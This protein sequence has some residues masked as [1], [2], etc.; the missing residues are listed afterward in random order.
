ML[1]IERRKCHSDAARASSGA[2]ALL[3]MHQEKRDG[4]GRQAREFVLPVPVSVA[5]PPADIGAPRSTT[6]SPPHSP[7]PP[8]RPDRHGACGGRSPRSGASDSPSTSPARPPAASPARRAEHRRANPPCR[9][10]RADAAT[11]PDPRTRSRDGEK[12]ER[13]RFARQRLTE[14]ARAA[15]RPHRPGVPAPPTRRASSPDTASRLRAKNSHRASS[16]SPISRPS[17]GET[18][19]RVVFAQRQAILGA[20]GEHAI[21]LRRAARDQIVDQHADIGLAA[22][23]APRL[24]LGAG[25]RRIDA[26]EQTLRRRL[27][28]ARGA[29]D[30]AGE[31]Q[32]ADELALQARLQTP[33][34]EEIVFD[35][36]AGAR[37]VRALEA[38]EWCARSPSARRT[39]GWW[40]CRSDRPRA[41]RAPRAR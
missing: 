20:A 19:I 33:G 18:Q 40:R 3:E 27:F 5:E 2:I 22:L 29:V 32:A 38:R 14:L 30:L 41:Y 6:R 35:G 10:V 16:T 26:G 37:D 25:E 34:I 7:C 28:V 11:A 24:A 9:A 39:A 21:R 23:R 13:M 8:A 1:K 4:R 17:V 15:R 36:V 31:K 12:L